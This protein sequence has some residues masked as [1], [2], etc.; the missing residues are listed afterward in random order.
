[1]LE[2]ASTASMLNPWWLRW[3]HRKALSRHEGWCGSSLRH[4]TWRVRL[5]TPFALA[6]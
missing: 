5:A 6:R 1:M 3:K 4:D 2:I